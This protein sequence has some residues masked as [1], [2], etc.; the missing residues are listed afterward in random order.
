M[1]IRFKLIEISAV[2]FVALSVSGCG[3]LDVW[4]FGGGKAAD[5]SGRIANATQYICKG[6]KN[7][8]V[9]MLDNGNAAWIIFAD[10]EVRFDKT[11]ATSGA[12]YSN[13]GSV[14]DIVGDKVTLQDGPGVSYVDCKVGDK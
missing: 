10:R 5:R 9:R 13:A 14:L 2:L 7:F 8:H 3:S 11:A 1:K 6:G 12:H 4:P